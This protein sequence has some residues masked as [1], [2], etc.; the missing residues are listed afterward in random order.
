[1]SVILLDRR[2]FD[3]LCANSLCAAQDALDYRFEFIEFT[4]TLYHNVMH[5]IS[6]LYAQQC[7]F[8]VHS[9]RG[10]QSKSQQRRDD[11]GNSRTDDNIIFAERKIKINC[12]KIQT[13]KR[14]AAKNKIEK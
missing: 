10:T 14:A 12:A 13:K 11:N 2:P 4:Y 3:F 1:M 5:S 8:S 7:T 9:K 6:T